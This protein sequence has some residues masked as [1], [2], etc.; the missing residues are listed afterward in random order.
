MIPQ[1]HKIIYSINRTLKRPR[2][3]EIIFAIKKGLFI[4][5]CELVFRE[6]IFVLRNSNLSEK[7]AQLTYTSILSVV[8]LLAILFTFIHTVNGLNDFFVQ[9]IS[10][11]IIKHF[12]IV[13]GLQISEYLHILIKNLEVKELGI[14]SLV[15]FLVTVVLLLLRIEDTFDEIMDIKGKLSL[16]NRLTKC[17]VILTITPFILGLASIKSDQFISWITIKDFDSYNTLAIKSFRMG[18]GMFFQAL[19]FVIIYYIIPSK[20]LNFKVVLFGGVISSLL[21]EGLQFL[22]VYLARR[23]FSGDPIHMYGTAP[24]IAVLFFVWLRIIWIITLFGA[25][26]TVSCQRII[27]YKHSL[28]KQ[29]YPRKSLADCLTVYKIISQQFQNLN[30]ATTIEHIV[31]VSY[32]NKKDA[33]DWV[34]YLL[35]HKFICASG[36]ISNDVLY[37]PTYKSIM[38][39]KN[40][41]SFLKELLTNDDLEKDIM[42]AEISTLFE[43]HKK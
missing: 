27:Y 1:F 35:H 24:L 26:L 6:S 23:A 41:P 31:K 37:I 4:K 28:S 21:F 17:W 14:I 32:L 34:E 42:L 5:K 22:N 9:T 18:F 30:E 25:A 19:F 33:E 15:T 36:E 13:A 3:K 38:S 7:S 8:P 39:E 10:P 40:R 43:K 29:L 2:H 11:T 12:G 16:F 20:R